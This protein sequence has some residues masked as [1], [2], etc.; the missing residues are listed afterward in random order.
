MVFEN[1]VKYG[2]LAKVGFINYNCWPYFGLMAMT[3]VYNF[4][5]VFIEYLIYKKILNSPFFIFAVQSSFCLYILIFPV[6]VLHK[7]EIDESVRYVVPIALLLYVI[8]LL[9]YISYF[10]INHYSRK[11]KNLYSIK[12][13]VKYPENITLRNFFY[14][15][16]APTLCYELNYPRNSKIRI[17]FLMKRATEAIFL[18]QL[19]N[20]MSQQW[21]IPIIKNSI[22][23]FIENDFIKVFEG[24]LTL[25]IPNISMWLIFFYWYFHSTLN[26]VAELLKF[27]DR[28]FYRDWWNATSASYFWRNWNLPVHKWASRHIYLPMIRHGY[29]SFSAKCVVFLISAVMHEYVVSISV[30]SFNVWIFLGMSAQVPLQIITSKVSNPRYS[31]AIIW[32]SLILGQPVVYILYY[33]DYYHKKIANK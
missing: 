3:L 9:K 32:L 8:L 1:Y 20:I 30:G 11:Y 29:S 10:Q 16:F 12:G 15:Y 14:F 17:Y 25:C 6:Y 21:I 19:L 7:I 28:D 23:P 27:G 18:F 5:P 2:F 33:Y 22:D 13:E 4:I 26:V 31:N 24:T